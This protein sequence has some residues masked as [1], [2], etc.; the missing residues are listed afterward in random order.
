MDACSESSSSF[1]RIAQKTSKDIARG[2]KVYIGLYIVSIT[3][4]VVINYLDSVTFVI[5]LIFL[6]KLNLLQ[7]KICNKFNLHR[8][9]N[10]TYLKLKQ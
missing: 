8:K 7:K 2:D 1:G 10:Q 4:E 9:I 5:N 6:C 3:C